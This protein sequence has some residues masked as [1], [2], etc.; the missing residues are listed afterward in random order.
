MGAGTLCGCAGK[1]AGG[2]EGW[3]GMEGGGAGVGWARGP[4]RHGRPVVP[5]K[6][7]NQKRSIVSW[8]ENTP[9]AT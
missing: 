1:G 7:K 2:G 8:K 3:T 4:L 6:H 9:A 5:L